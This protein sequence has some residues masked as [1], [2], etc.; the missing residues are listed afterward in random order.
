MRNITL[1]AAAFLALTLAASGC[2]SS[3]ENVSS[4]SQSVVVHG[5]TLLVSDIDDTIRRTDVLSKTAAVFNGLQFH[6]PFSGMRLLYTSWHNDNTAN[7]KITYLSASPGPLVLA[8]EHFLEESDFPG[9]T[10]EIKESVV[11][12]RKFSESAADFKTRKLHEMY[13]A[14]VATNAVPDTVILIGDNGEQDMIAYGNYVDYVAEKGGDTSRIYSFIHHAYD[15]PKGTEIA[16]PHRAWVTAA[17]LAAQLSELGLIND[18]T[19]TEVLSQVAMDV[20]NQPTTVIPSF[21]GCA[22]W[23]AWPKLPGKPATDV[24]GTY[25]TV[26]NAVNDLC[27]N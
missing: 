18:G 23:S 19:L 24:A 25:Q 20:T 14:A 27:G 13:D 1:V 6:N 9:D 17:D 3:S 8:G 10:S 26:Q 12:G 16:A 11:S 15:T 22:Q 4:G 21:M 5:K 2:A 7:K